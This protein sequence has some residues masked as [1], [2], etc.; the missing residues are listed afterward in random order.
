MTIMVVSF[1]DMIIIQYDQ[2][3]TL[4][5][6][7]DKAFFKTVFIIFR[8]LMSSV[9]YLLKSLLERYRVSVRQVNL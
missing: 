6:K 5:Y 3:P 9:P 7:G 8:K 2:D 1:F 4:E